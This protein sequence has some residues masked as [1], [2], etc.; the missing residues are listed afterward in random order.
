MI[1][2]KEL[3]VSERPRERM[4]SEGEGA[5][6]NTEL[7]AILIGSGTGKESAVTLASRVLKL[8]EDG[9]AYLSTVHAK[10]LSAIRGIGPAKACSILAALELGKRVATLET[11]KKIRFMHPE[12]IAG[13]FMEDLRREKKEHFYILLLNA[14]QEMAGKELISIGNISGAIVDPRDVFRP[15]VK[16]GAA[17]IILVHNHPSG[18]PEPSKADISITKQMVEAGDVMQIKVLDHLIIGDGKFVSLRRRKLI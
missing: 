1:G 5:L 13:L 10:E 3:P 15:A 6:S 11:K 4:I 12:D 2:I 7:L 17:G 8:D 9:L 16:R 14:K 18:D